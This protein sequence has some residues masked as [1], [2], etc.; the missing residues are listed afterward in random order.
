M[1]IDASDAISQSKGRNKVE[2]LETFVG[3]VGLCESEKV[4]CI[5]EGS[6][7]SYGVVEDSGI[8]KSS[9]EER[10]LSVLPSLMS[11]P[12]KIATIVSN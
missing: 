7:S 4:T 6:K 9:D 8:D 3:N 10:V 5:V 1:V 11:G 12:L 2:N